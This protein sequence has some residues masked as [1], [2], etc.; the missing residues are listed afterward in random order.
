M[1]LVCGVVVLLLGCNV[2]VL[3]CCFVDLLCVVGSVCVFVC[4]CV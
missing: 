3:V 1:L 4:V 2:G